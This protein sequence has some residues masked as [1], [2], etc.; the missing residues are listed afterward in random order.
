MNTNSERSWTK[1]ARQILG[2]KAVQN[3]SDGSEGQ[4]ALVTPCRGPIDFSLCATR[5]TG[6][7]PKRSLDRGGRCGGCE[8]WTHYIVDLSNE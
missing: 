1:E 2:K 3:L 7:K 6:E 5:E 8:P 4:F